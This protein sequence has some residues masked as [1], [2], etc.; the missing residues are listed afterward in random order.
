MYDLL[1]QNKKKVFLK[2]VGNRTTL[3]PIDLYCMGT[4]QRH[5]ISSFVSY[6]DILMAWGWIND[7]S[8]IFGWTNPSMFNSASY[9]I[10]KHVSIVTSGLFW[11]KL[12]VNDK[13]TTKLFIS[14]N[15]N[16]C[17]PSAAILTVFHI[18]LTSYTG[19]KAKSISATGFKIWCC[20]HFIKQIRHFN[21]NSTEGKD[22]AMG[23]HYVYDL[24][25]S[26]RAAVQ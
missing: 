12:Y 17:R 5:K 18:N 10:K 26:H 23:C 6:T 2:N 1:L 11:A 7:R 13:Q 24:T 20:H 19:N 21:T 4:K 22:S 8:F 3:H 15:N 14:C 16:N 25:V 9:N